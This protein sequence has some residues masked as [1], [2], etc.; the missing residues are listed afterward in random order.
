M[1]STLRLPAPAKL[2]LFLHITGQRAD[3]YHELQTLFQ[4]LD[5]ADDLH[6]KPRT[7]GVIRVHGMT[8]LP[9]GSNLIAHAARKLQKHAAEGAGVDITINKNLPMGGGLGGGSSDAATTLVALN[10]IWKLAMSRQQLADLG[11]TLGA[12]VPVFVH[13][14]AAWA[15][16][17]G[18]QLTPVEP[19]EPWYLVLIPDCMISTADVF[20][21]PDLTRNTAKRR[22]RTAFEGNDNAFRNDCENVVRSL[23]PAVDKALEWLSQYGEARLTGTGS[24]VFCPF[25]T[26]SAAHKAYANR[27]SGINGFIARGRN[28]S[29]LYRQ[30]GELD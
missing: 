3:G 23:Y 1:P 21:H 25:E 13:G 27:P 8:E 20:R 24:C 16:G 12:D 11:L 14:Q 15:E 30:L 29:P 5:M 10:R 18:E 6:F 28:R 17:V 4:F 22:I 2:N 7:D 26:Q 9:E 19:V